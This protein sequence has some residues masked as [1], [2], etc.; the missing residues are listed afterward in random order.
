MLEDGLTSSME[1]SNTRE[2]TGC[3]TTRETPRV[4]WNPKAH[5]RI[6]EGS[7]LVLTLSQTNRVN[8]PHTLSPRSILIL[9]T[10][11]RL[12]LPSGSGFPTNNQYMF[13]FSPI[14]VTCLAHIALLDLIVL[15]ILGEEYKLRRSWLCNFL[16]LQLR[17]SFSV[18]SSQSMVFP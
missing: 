6:H 12:G 14:R 10:H 16:T 5:Y 17:D 3:A 15:I 13:L 1:L 9:S 11:L 8:N 18:T 2:T 4:L 7:P